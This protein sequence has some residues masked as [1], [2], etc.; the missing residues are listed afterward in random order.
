MCNALLYILNIGYSPTT[1]FFNDIC[2]THTFDL[3]LCLSC[4]FSPQAEAKLREAGTWRYLLRSKPE[5]SSVGNTASTVI[6]YRHGAD[7]KKMTHSQLSRSQEG[8]Y[9]LNNNPITGV[10]EHGAKISYPTAISTVLG[11]LVKQVGKQLFPVRSAAS[12]ESDTMDFGKGYVN[13]SFEMMAAFLSEL[14]AIERTQAE[15]VLAGHAI[16]GGFILRKKDAVRVVVSSCGWCLCCECARAC[17][18]QC[19]QACRRLQSTIVFMHY[20]PICDSGFFL[21]HV[22]FLLF[23]FC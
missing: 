19:L 23:T 10:T 9:M 22:S 1:L 17:L 4:C 12:F 13:T 21:S 6:S 14:P 8:V 15:T 11:L 3:I 5:Q 2:H 18:Q 20:L 7:G 16:D